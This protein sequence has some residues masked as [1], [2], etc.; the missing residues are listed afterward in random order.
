ML[1]MPQTLATGLDEEY[2]KPKNLADLVI[3]LLDEDAVAQS[4]RLRLLLLYLVYRDGIL[5]ADIVKLLSHAQLK[6]I[7]GDVIYNLAYLARELA[8]HSRMQDHLVRR[9]S[10][11]SRRR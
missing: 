11:V 9:C 5:P 3:R 10:H 4:D 2:K 8:V 6:A 1:I 7:D